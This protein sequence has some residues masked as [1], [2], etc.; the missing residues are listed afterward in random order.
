M[1][2]K[3][4]RQPISKQKAKVCPRMGCNG[5]LLNVLVFKFTVYY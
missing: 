4:K 2:Y 3:E 5:I 1:S